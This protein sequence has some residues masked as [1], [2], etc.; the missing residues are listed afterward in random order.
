[1]AQEMIVWIAAG[2]FSLIGWGSL[3]HYL[4]IVRNWPAARGRVVDNVAEWQETSNGLS[5]EATYYP[6]L[7]YGDAQGYSHQARGL[8]G[9]SSKWETGET[10]ALHFDPD[11]P[12]D[13]RDINRA[14]RLAFAGTFIMFGLAALATA[15]HWVD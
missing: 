13:M 2:V 1:M 11:N 8:H 4:W 14:S 5:R 6:L 9:K 10:V 3:I 7:E 15:L 12:D